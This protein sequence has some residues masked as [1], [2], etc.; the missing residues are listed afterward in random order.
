VH[1]ASFLVKQTCSYYF[2]VPLYTCEICNNFLSKELMG[3]SSFGGSL[4]SYDSRCGETLG[5]VVRV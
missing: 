2:Q 3:S 1:G 4:E 5:K